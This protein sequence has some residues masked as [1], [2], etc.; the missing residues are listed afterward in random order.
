MYLQFFLHHILYSITIVKKKKEKEIICVHTF[1]IFFHALPKLKN[2]FVFSLHSHS[3]VHF[4]LIFLSAFTFTFLHTNT[5]VSLSLSLLYIFH[6]SET[7]P[8]SN[9]FFEIRYLRC[10]FD[11]LKWNQT[12]TKSVSL[13]QWST[14]FQWSSLFRQWMKA[15]TMVKQAEAMIKQSFPLTQ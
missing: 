14:L 3:L 9:F 6:L 2:S 13:S 12:G 15:R 10:T 11:P 5:Q 1:N 8:N 4:L 7:L